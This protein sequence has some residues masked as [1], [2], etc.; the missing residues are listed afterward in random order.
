MTNLKIRVVDEHESKEAQELLKSIGYHQPYSNF[1]LHDGWVCFNGE[2]EILC[3]CNSQAGE[4]IEDYKKITIP[5]LRDLV[6]LK[7]NDKNDRN[8][9][10]P[11]YDDA[12][13][14]LYSKS[15]LFVFHLPTQTWKESDLNNEPEVLARLQQ[16]EK[17][18]KEYLIPDNGGYR[19]AVQD[20]G[21]PI[22]EDWFEIPE[23]TEVVTKGVGKANFWK[24][25]DREF[26]FNSRGEWSNNYGETLNQ[27]L[28]R[29]PKV[30]IV[31]QREQ[32]EPFLTPEC[33]LNDQYAEKDN[34]NHPSHYTQ[35]KVECIDALESATIGKSG[36]EAVCVANVIKYL[37]RYEEKNG[38]EDVKKAQF[39]LNRLLAT[40][41]N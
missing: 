22:A 18:M 41:E 1:A 8:A 13:L 21:L 34:V 40:L 4:E 20:A 38:I 5:E 9:I 6:I 32:D 12:N 15:D 33:T 37:W 24:N 35:G 23:G 19:V 25:Q 17:N 39:Y 14:Y 31:W 28:E 2:H 3:V 7:R 30:E 36:I 16:I 27:Y 26:Y 11:E 29:N 10:D